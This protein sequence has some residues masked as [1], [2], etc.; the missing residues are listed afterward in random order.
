[1]PRARAGCAH[2]GRD[3]VGCHHRAGL[4]RPPLP[5]RATQ[6]PRPLCRYPFRANFQL[7]I[8]VQ[9]LSNVSREAHLGT[10]SR[11]TCT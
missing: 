4:P 1:M 10:L 6:L 5:V 11:M 9:Q 7:G 2:L 8:V 3:E